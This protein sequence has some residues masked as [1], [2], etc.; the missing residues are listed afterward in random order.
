[1]QYVLPDEQ[2]S[3][4]ICLP[5]LGEI[6][7]RI[8]IEYDVYRHEE[9]NKSE[10]L[11]IVTKDQTSQTMHG[12]TTIKLISKMQELSTKETIAWEKLL[13]HGT[14]PWQLKRT[15]MLGDNILFF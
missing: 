5:G 2:G 9:K 1:M 6:I 15:T 13:S 8:E 7:E 10:T 3:Y 14:L 12:W 11:N 4:L